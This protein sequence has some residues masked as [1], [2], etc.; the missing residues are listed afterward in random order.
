MFI[1]SNQDFIYHKKGF[2]P[3]SVCE[4]IIDYYENH[5]LKVPGVVYTGVNGD[6]VI[7]RE[8]KDSMEVGC[9]FS[10]SQT[11]CLF[12]LHHYLDQL[13]GEYKKKYEFLNELMRWNLSPQ[14][15]IQKYDPMGGYFSLHSEHGPGNDESRRIMAWMVYLN[16]VYDGGHT[17]FPSQ[18]KKFQ[19][20]VGDALIWPAFWTHPHHGI[21]SK[22]ETKYIVTGWMGYSWRNGDINIQKE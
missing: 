11:G 19:P 6:L 4:S 8:V 22:T 13:I 15:N 9:D 10:T 16:D 17:S 2:V 1:N 18:K 5:P 12:H 20:R 7:D 3:S 14:Y 21:V